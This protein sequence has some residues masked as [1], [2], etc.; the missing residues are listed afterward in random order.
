[1]MEEELR[2]LLRKQGWNLFARTRYEKRY[3]YAQKWRMPQVYIG[4][5]SK[6]DQITDEQVLEKLA[7]AK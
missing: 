5:A 3:L 6:L 4:P 7:K 1:M 2:Q